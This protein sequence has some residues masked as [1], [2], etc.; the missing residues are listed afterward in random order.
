MSNSSESV[1][2]KLIKNISELDIKDYGKDFLRTWDKDIDS[3]KATLYT[4]QTLKEMYTNGISPKVFESGIAI[5]IFKDQSTRTRYSHASAA[6]LLGLSNEELDMGKSQVGHGETVMETANMISFLTR[7]ISIRDDMYLGVGHN[8]MKEF[9]DSLQKGYEEKVLPYRPSVIN[10]QCDEDHPTQSMSDLLHLSNYYGGIEKLKGK[11]LV[12]SWAYSPSYGKPLSVPQGVI[13]LMTR[14]GINITLAYPEGYNLIP[15]IE[16]LAKKNALKNKSSFKVVSDMGEA[17]K[18][19]D[20]VYPKSWA[21]YEV[22]KRRTELLKNEDEDGLNKLEKEALENNAKFLNWECT[23]DLMKLTKDGKAL[24]MHCLPAD[25]T[26]VS[27]KNGE[28]SKSVFEKFRTDTYNEAGYKPYIIAAMIFIGQYG[29]ESSSV[30]KSILNRNL[31]IM[32]K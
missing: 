3:L 1:I 27:C 4:A 22:M 14:F 32:Y 10:L 13:A 6:N 17:F 28:V 26:D 16:E 18:D 11:K 8:Y 9:A 7:S 19:A 15:E 30:L 2:S 20:I 12:M 24:Y 31:N 29:K 21:P 5:S 23:E 25:I